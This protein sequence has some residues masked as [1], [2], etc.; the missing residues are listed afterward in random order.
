MPDE[1]K[2]F[3]TALALLVTALASFV[4]AFVLE[5]VKHMIVSYIIVSVYGILNIANLPANVVTTINNILGDVMNAFGLAGVIAIIAFV[6]VIIMI[7]KNSFGRAPGGD[8][9]VVT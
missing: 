8:S 1:P 5:L 9:P 7:L 4:T 2:S 6:A 3:V